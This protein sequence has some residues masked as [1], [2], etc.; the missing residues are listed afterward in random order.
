[1]D[2][3]RPSRSSLPA[4]RLA[5][6][7]LRAV[8]GGPAP[9]DH[10]PVE[11]MGERVTEP[12][13]AIRL[14]GIAKPFGC[15]ARS[16]NGVLILDGAPY[17]LDWPRFPVSPENVLAPLSEVRGRGADEAARILVVTDWDEEIM[18]TED[19]FRE[20]A[21]GY[22]IQMPHTITAAPPTETQV[23]TGADWVVYFSP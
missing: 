18:V 9:H 19:V 1:M 16:E 13:A 17:P 20:F 2:P 22:V 14:A 15:H 4:A 11:L 10:G 12:E 5:I 23:T 21:A 8:A 3:V 6:F 7:A